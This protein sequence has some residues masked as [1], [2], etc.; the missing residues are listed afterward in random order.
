MER[1]LRQILNEYS[2]KVSEANLQASA[3][4]LESANHGIPPAGINYYGMPASFVSYKILYCPHYALY[5]LLLRRPV[6]K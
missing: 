6:F 1:F 4:V 3:K 5:L 2:D